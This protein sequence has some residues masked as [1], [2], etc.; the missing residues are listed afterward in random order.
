MAWICKYLTYIWIGVVSLLALLVHSLKVKNLKLEAER[1][2]DNLKREEALRKQ[3]ENDDALRVE[4]INKTMEREQRARE[5]AR[6]G[7][8]NHFEG[9]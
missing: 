9:Q 2:E 8:R 1:V 7:K 5:A 3:Q 6:Q 4:A